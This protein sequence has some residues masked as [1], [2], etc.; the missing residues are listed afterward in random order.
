MTSVFVAKRTESGFREDFREI[1]I[2]CEGSLLFGFVV[3]R[4]R[5]AWRGR[6][7][8]VKVEGK[9]CECERSGEFREEGF[10]GGIETLEGFIR[11][12]D[13]RGIRVSRTNRRLRWCRFCGCWCLGF[14]RGRFVVAALKISGGG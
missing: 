12:G 10:E 4:R 9:A 8:V 11:A 3:S 14:R 2:Y 13:G 1:G 7:L 6:R 5:G